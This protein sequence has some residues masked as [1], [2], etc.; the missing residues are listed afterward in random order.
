MKLN[1]FMNFVQ[2]DEVNMDQ[3]SFTNTQFNK[4]IIHRFTNFIHILVNFF[5]LQKLQNMI[6]SVMFNL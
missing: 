2:N 4:V 6:F 5:F 3:I 1:W